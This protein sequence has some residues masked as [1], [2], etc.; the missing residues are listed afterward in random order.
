MAKGVIETA[1]PDYDRLSVAELEV[2][3]SVV[4]DLGREQGWDDEKV[5]G[6]LRSALEGRRVALYPRHASAVH[7]FED[8][9]VALRVRIACAQCRREDRQSPRRTTIYIARNVDG[10][11]T[12]S[13]LS[14]G[15]MVADLRHDEFRCGEHTRNALLAL[16]ADT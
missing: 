7:V 5:I 4:R 11:W 3:I 8:G 15:D 16:S 9:T 14:N 12:R 1:G 2:R 13:L 6:A 10:S